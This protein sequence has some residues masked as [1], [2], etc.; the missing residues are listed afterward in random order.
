MAEVGD[1]GGHRV[2]TPYIA[3]CAAGQDAPGRRQRHPELTLRIS[4]GLA[5]GSHGHTSTAGLA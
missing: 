1:G 5:S 3:V 4:T 2:E